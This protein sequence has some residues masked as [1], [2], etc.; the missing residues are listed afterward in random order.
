MQS[1]EGTPGTLKKYKDARRVWEAL[2]QVHNIPGTEWQQRSQAD[3]LVV[4]RAYV[5]DT[6]SRCAKGGIS[7]IEC[8]SAAVGRLHVVAGKEATNPW[9]H[10]SMRLV[11]KNLKKEVKKVVTKKH[12]PRLTS[13]RYEMIILKALHVS[14]RFR[15]VAS[16]ACFIN[17]TSCTV[18]FIE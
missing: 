6:I 8:M 18:C 13:V 5:D 17:V 15:F 14:E 1:K 7:P 12:A 3:L 9:D 10:P 4:A 11:V 2:L 16:Q